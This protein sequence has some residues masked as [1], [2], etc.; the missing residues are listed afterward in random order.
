M[1]YKIC[2][3]L[4]CFSALILFSSAIMESQNP[5]WKGEIEY[6]NGFSDWGQIKERMK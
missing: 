1:K 2:L 3:F 5:Q 4:V 6:E